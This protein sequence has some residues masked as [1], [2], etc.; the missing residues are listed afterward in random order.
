M[1]ARRLAALVVPVVVVVAAGCGK[2]AAP[3]CAATGQA[4]DRVVDE[5]LASQPPTQRDAMAPR[6]KKLADGYRKVIVG[7]C[8]ADQW[9]AEIMGC[10]ASATTAAA[11][12]ACRTKLSAGQR[13]QLDD[14]MS[15]R[16]DEMVEELHAK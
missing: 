14:A 1:R 6:A 13:K 5:L 4:A 3:D 11:L 12:D 8:A 15:K 2:A 10:M 16:A 7:R 9:S